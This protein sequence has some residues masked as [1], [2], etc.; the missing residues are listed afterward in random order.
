MGVVVGADMPGR[1]Y[2]VS[3]FLWMVTK[4]F[5]NIISRSRGL[6]GGVMCVL[7]IWLVGVCLLGVCYGVG[8]VCLGTRGLFEGRVMWG[9]YVIY[10]VFVFICVC[11]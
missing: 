1:R 2:Q 4:V 3:S 6:C 5:G 11:C 10:V 9:M 8:A 7:F